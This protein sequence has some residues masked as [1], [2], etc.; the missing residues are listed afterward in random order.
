MSTRTA[1]AQE[2]PIKVVGSSTFGRYG[3]ISCEKTINLFESDQFLVPFAGYKR[4]LDLLPT[5]ATGSGRGI[6]HSIRG[7]FL[8][9][10]INSNVYRI[11]FT[12]GPQL[13]G[14]LNTNYGEVV[15][16]ENLN[17]QICIVDGVNIWIYNWG[18]SSALVAQT[19]AP[20][21]TNVL[22]PNYVCFH[23]TFFLIGNG[24][25]NGSSQSWYAYS[26]ATDTTIAIANTQGGTFALETKPDYPV[27]VKRIPGQAANVLVFGTSVC[28]IYTQIGGAQNYRRN[29]TASID[30]GCASVSTIASSDQYIAWLAVNESNGPVIMAYTGQD[31]APISSDGIDYLMDGIKF[32]DQ[33]TAMFC[34]VDGHLFYQLT[35]YNPADNLTLGYDFSLKK[36]YNL[37]DA[38]LN[39]HPARDYVYYKQKTYFISL[40][41]PAIY[42]SS[43]DLNTYDD[44]I[45][46]PYEV[47]YLPSKVG[48]IQRIRICDTIRQENNDRFMANVLTFTI[49]QGE[50]PNVSGASLDL[51]STLL[52]EGS[53]TESAYPLI[54]EMGITLVDESSWNGQSSYTPPYQPRVD[55]TLSY[56]DGATWSATVSKALNPV[57][58]RKNILNWNRLGACNSLIIKLRFWGSG[59]LVAGNG[60]LE[61]Y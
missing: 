53:L 32:P 22:I 30:Y 31:I 58:Y 44:N 11:D 19:G 23:N 24:N 42:E 43:T 49:E 51:I 18:T 12:I 33:S 52:A 60:M 38:D 50:D 39:F 61:I 17:N 1:E 8:I 27:A 41:Q 10:V 48:D 36:F 9:G 2:L 4:V 5:G 28:E 21:S 16:D 35:F 45:F 26:F 25:K 56:D 37:T 47:G 40:N 13:I 6:F 55:L 15:I 46:Q 3:K 14:S 29:N 7:N 20:L 59:R 54:S 57:G 34:R